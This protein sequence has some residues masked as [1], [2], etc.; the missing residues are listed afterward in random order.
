MDTLG[1]RTKSL[2]RQMSHA[3]TGSPGSPRGASSKSRLGLSAAAEAAIS[4]VD[5]PA[6]EGPDRTVTP[7]EGTSKAMS[8][9]APGKA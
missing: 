1:G 5:F 6:P 4:T 7:G 8:I 2:I 9:P 3:R